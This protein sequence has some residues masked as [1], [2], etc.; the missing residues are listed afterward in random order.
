MPITWLTFSVSRRIWPSQCYYSLLYKLYFCTVQ[1]TVTKSV[2]CTK[3]FGIWIELIVRLVFVF[4]SWYL[5]KYGNAEKSWVTAEFCVLCDND[6]GTGIV[7]YVET[8]K[9]IFWISN[10][11]L[12]FFRKSKLVVWRLTINTK[13]G[14]Y[15]IVRKNIILKLY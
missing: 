3:L 7:V 9:K 14:H 13:I 12:V 5:K 6:D 8:Y 11:K 1:I 10:L 4:G 2:C 15:K